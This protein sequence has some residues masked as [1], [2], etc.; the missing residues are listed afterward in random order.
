MLFSTAFSI[1]LTWKP[2]EASSMGRSGAAS[3]GFAGDAFPAQPVVVRLKARLPFYHEPTEPV[4]C[5]GDGVLLP[6]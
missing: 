1:E 6:P 3:A 2:E 5:E 4:E